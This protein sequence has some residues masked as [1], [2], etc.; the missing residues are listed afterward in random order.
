M[1]PPNP[2]PNRR[3]PPPERRCPR[4]PRPLLGRH[5]AAGPLSMAGG[6]WHPPPP[7]EPRTLTSPELVAGVGEDEE[8]VKKNSCE[9]GP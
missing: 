1:P 3:P 9:E 6:E 2:G 7:Q 5:A 8:C 4:R